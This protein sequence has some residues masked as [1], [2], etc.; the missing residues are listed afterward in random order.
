M[1]NTLRE[2]YT[3]FMTSTRHHDMDND[4]HFV[5]ALATDSSEIDRLHELPHGTKIREYQHRGAAILHE[6]AKILLLDG[7]PVALQYIE[8]TM[9]PA[10]YNSIGYLNQRTDDVMN[11]QVPIPFMIDPL[12]DWQMSPED[13][14][15]RTLEALN[16]SEQST[17][18]LLHGHIIDHMPQ[19]KVREAGRNIGNSALWLANVTLPEQYPSHDAFDTQYAVRARSLAMVER[20]RK[21]G[22]VVGMVPSLAA[23]TEIDSTYAAFLRRNAPMKKVRDAIVQSQ[24]S[25]GLAA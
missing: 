17:S 18:N 24:E 15:S 14:R 11:R 5:P 23:M 16:L 3:T 9:A 7:D 13:A 21:M 19:Y 1:K 25:Y 10:P 22:R 8:D 20:S 2:P 4:P 12:A 6:T